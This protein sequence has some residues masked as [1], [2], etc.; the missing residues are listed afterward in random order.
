MFL[1]AQKA[2]AKHHSYHAFHHQ[3][4]TLLPPQN[5]RKSQNPLQ[6]P[7]FSPPNYF[8]QKQDLTSPSHHQSR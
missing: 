7:H 5:T 4:T 2:H 8:S 3:L 6:K 1:A